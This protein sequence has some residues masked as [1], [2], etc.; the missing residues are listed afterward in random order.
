[1][2]TLNRQ[3]LAAALREHPGLIPIRIDARK[4]TLEWLD[5]EAYHCYE[6]F[7]Q[8]GIDR[9]AALKH[10][11]GSAPLVRCAT[12]WRVLDDPELVDNS[13]PPTGFIF[14][15]GRSGSTLL[16]KVLARDR[17]HLTFGE[18]DVL[19]QMLLALTE[20]GAHPLA[21][22]AAGMSI[23]R[24][25]LLAMSRR[26]LPEHT[27]CFIKF[28]SFN[29]LCFDFINTV[30]PDVPAIFLYR[31]PA[32]S[33]SSFRRNPPPWFDNEGAD[34]KPL[35]LGRIAD[36]SP[37][38]IE[39]ELPALIAEF[40]QA[41]LRATSRGMKLLNY[42][43]LSAANFC[44]ILKALNG[45]ESSEAQLAQMQTQ[46]S[47]DAK[48]EWRAERFNHAG[49]ATRDSESGREEENLTELYQQLA[50]SEFN[51]IPPRIGGE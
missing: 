12:D 47:Y 27:A 45:P 23:Y 36:R 40:Y 43:D 11:V 18:P 5:L 21:S 24:H 14:H 37:A 28:T 25:L 46:F 19:N 22:S 20:N 15:A 42:Q 32:R 16:T 38:G 10:S 44:T 33:L 51:I 8:K 7:F 2:L 49:R 26:R 39:W 4:A 3:E 31:D 35:L 1:M 30:F 29:I 13:I 41:G 50:Q 9:F 6:G 48:E 34:L 17:R